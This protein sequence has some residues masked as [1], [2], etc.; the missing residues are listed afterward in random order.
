MKKTNSLYVS[1]PVNALVKG[2]LREDK[3]LEEVLEHGNFGLGTFNDLD[4][5]MVLLDGIFYDLHSDGKTNIADVTIQTPYACV[6]QFE[7]ETSLHV[8]EDLSFGLLKRKIDQMV[9][10]KNLIY[11]IE[12][13]GDFAS[14][15]A[16]SVP[17]QETY[18]PLVD[19]AGDQ[20]EF[21]FSNVQGTL[22]GFWT[23]DFMDSVTVPGYHLHF[24]SDDK[25]KGGHLLDC[26]CSSVVIKIQSI[27]QLTLDLPHSIDYLTAKLEG[28]VRKDLDKRRTLVTP[29]LA[30]CCE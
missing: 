28:D 17:K 22:V 29:G 19:I 20:T 6:T 3:T 14:I 27:D 12:V 1:A 7:P 11:A 5:E 23:P 18:R 10:S 2:I 30:V 26:A 24:L 25:T 8:N 21:F 16:R 15:K 4:G 9:L 13:S